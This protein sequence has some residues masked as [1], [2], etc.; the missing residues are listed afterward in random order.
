MKI[1]LLVYLFPADVSHDQQNAHMLYYEFSK[2]AKRPFCLGSL[3][4]GSLSDI[5]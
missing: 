4:D 2:I 3:S 1:L 5:L